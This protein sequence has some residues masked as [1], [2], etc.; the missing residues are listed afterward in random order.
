[1]A[2]AESRRRKPIRG[3]FARSVEFEFTQQERANITAFCRHYSLV[4]DYNSPRTAEACRL[5]AILGLTQGQDVASRV[6]HALRA[7]VT[8]SV[9]HLGYRLAKQFPTTQHVAPDNKK[10]DGGMWAK[11]VYDTPSLRMLPAYKLMF[12]D[13]EGR[14]RDELLAKYLIEQG[15]VDLDMHSVASAYSEHAND[16]Y[17]KMKEIEANVAQYLSGV[18]AEWAARGGAA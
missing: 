17:R 11:L 6:S 5:L 3:V 7:Q 12:R 10:A 13:E 8:M 9:G 2:S 15:L 18:L 16:L 1:M 14:L 4:D